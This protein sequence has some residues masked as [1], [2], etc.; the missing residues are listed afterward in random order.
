M[1]YARRAGAGQYCERMLQ[2]RGFNSFIEVMHA[3]SPAEASGTLSQYQR[4]S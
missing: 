3:T 2:A 1:K 4:R